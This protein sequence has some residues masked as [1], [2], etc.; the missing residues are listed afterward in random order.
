MLSWFKA[1]PW[2]MGIGCAIL[3]LAIVGVII[4]VLTK[5][6]WK[7]FGLMK[8]ED[9]KPFKWDRN[10]FPLA[11]WLHAALPSA[12][13]N[14]FREARTFLNEVAGTELFDLGTPLPA[15]FQVNR[16]AEGHIVLAMSTHV[17]STSPNHGNTSL[18]VIQHTGEIKKAVVTFP[19]DRHALA[20]PIT[21][22][23]MMHVLGFAHDEGKASLMHPQLQARPQHVTDDDKKRLANVADTDFHKGA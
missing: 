20:K 18:T 22:H 13:V 21:L 16:L 7:D 5:G 15:N 10:N 23:E 8:T 9:G 12:Y 2:T 4:G 1:A 19:P 14:A 6:R 3:L 17:D 11:V